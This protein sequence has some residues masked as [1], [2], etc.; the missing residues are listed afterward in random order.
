[1]ITHLNN[2]VIEHGACNRLTPHQGEQLF[3]TTTTT[4]RRRAV[5]TLCG[6]CPVRTPCL[7]RS[8]LLDVREGVVGGTTAYERSLL[9]QGLPSPVPWEQIAD[10]LGDDWTRV[11]ATPTERTRILFPLDAHR[12]AADTD[13]LRTH[14]DLIAAGAG[15]EWGDLSLQARLGVLTHQ[16]HLEQATAHAEAARRW[17]HTCDR[18]RS[19]YQ[20]GGLD[21]VRAHPGLGSWLRTQAVGA[22]AG[23]LPLLQR[24]RLLEIG[25]DLLVL[26][27]DRLEDTEHTLLDRTV[28]R[29]R[30]GAPN[31][32]V[33]AGCGPGVEAVVA[34]ASWDS[35]SRLR[36]VLIVA[37]AAGGATVD[38]LHTRYPVAREHIVALLTGAGVE[39]VHAAPGSA[40][41]RDCPGR[42]RIDRLA[43]DLAEGH[44]PVWTQNLAGR[45]RADRLLVLHGYPTIAALTARGPHPAAAQS[46]ARPVP[47][48]TGTGVGR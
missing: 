41:A 5:R 17:E 31:P 24:A 43:Q 1:M 9:T 12:R 18:V 42:A 45:R 36:E 38:A 21:A 47:S 48:P 6:P 7:V 44:L 13:R 28:D 30:A 32:V 37:D 23:T 2:T 34:R 25:A 29:L 15:L 26:D 8:Y 27:P 22:H 40:E 4:G 10:R 20:S 16:V 46:Q 3:F 11:L 14:L 33:A 35:L 19:A 39:A